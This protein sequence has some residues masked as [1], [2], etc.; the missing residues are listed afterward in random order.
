[1]G[2]PY[3]KA[4]TVRHGLQSPLPHLDRD[5][6]LTFCAVFHCQFWQHYG[7]HKLGLRRSDGLQLY[8][9]DSFQKFYVMVHSNATV[10]PYYHGTT[11]RTAPPFGHLEY[12]AQSWPD[13]HQTWLKTCITLY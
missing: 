5:L 7:A 6:A 2:Q 10:E 1:V 11:L 8:S 13:S 12:L 4:R 3:H 9:H